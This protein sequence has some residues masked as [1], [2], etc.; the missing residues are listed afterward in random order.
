MMV[1]CFGFVV[2]VAFILLLGKFSM[3]R[4]SK[5]G[6]YASAIYN[7]SKDIWVIRGNFVA[8][9][10]TIEYRRRHGKPG[11]VKYVD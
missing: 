2:G 4:M 9:G 1:F 3:T 5:R 6:E 10:K 7:K 8:L 11:S